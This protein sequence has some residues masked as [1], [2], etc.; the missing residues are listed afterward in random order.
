MTVPDRLRARA[1]VRARTRD[2]ILAAA[3]LGPMVALLAVVVFYPLGQALVLSVQDATLLGVDN[4]SFTGLANLRRMLDDAVFWEATANTVELTALSVGGSLVVG[5]CLALLLNEKFPF[6]N[7]LR[8]LALIPW[9]TSGVVISLLSLYMFN[10]EVGI[11]NHLLTSI[12]LTGDYVNW[13]GSPGNALWAIAIVNIWHQAPFTML[14]AL[15]A[16]QTVPQDLYESARMDGANALQQFRHITLPGISGVLGVVIVLQVAWNFNNFDLIWATTQ[17]GPINA[18]TTL[19]IYSYRAAFE[20]LEIG[21]AAMIGLVLL[22]FLL[23][24]AALYIRFLAVDKEE[25]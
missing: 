18:T 10:S 24:F 2:L 5:L 3:L 12:G 22:L 4:A 14:M 13:F 11:I 7:T 25:S 8:G 6:R 15:A 1:P 23:G 17:G 19:G 20:N 9:V 21:Y 16:L